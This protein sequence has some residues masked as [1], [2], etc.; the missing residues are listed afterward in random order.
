[1]YQKKL[2]SEKI[3][4]NIT[5]L[6]SKGYYKPGDKMPNE[7]Q[8]SEEL[9]ISRATLRE[10]IKSLESRNILE[11]RRGIGTFVAEAP[12]LSL[13][14]LG[15]EFIDIS[16]HPNAIVLSV[17][18]QA[19][20]MFSRIKAI[21]AKKIEELSCETI[22]KGEFAQ[23]YFQNALALTEAIGKALEDE[24]SYRLMKAIN[25]IFIKWIGEKN[26]RSDDLLDQLYQ[27]WLEAYK[28]KE[29]E[30]LKKNYSAMLD[31]I[32]RRLE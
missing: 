30:A 12:G 3:A 4:N 18:F 14:P 7:I 21:S 27:N 24:F 26:L 19:Y 2:L 5:E 29:S 6:I 13:D 15:S 28:N 8:L 1:M 9:S 31:W 11:V 17:Q 16:V 20:Q 22:L 10:A 25:P 32:E 23:S